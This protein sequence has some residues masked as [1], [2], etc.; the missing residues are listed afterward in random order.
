MEVYRSSN[1]Y[2]ICCLKLKTN[3]YIK[4][5][6]TA[7]KMYDDKCSCFISRR[8]NFAWLKSHMSSIFSINSEANATRLLENVEDMLIVKCRRWRND[9]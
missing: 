3:V 8:G 5:S 7:T 6:E 2:Y 4:T 1:L 9:L